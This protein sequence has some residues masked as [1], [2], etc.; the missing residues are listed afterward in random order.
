M[1]FPIKEPV[2]ELRKN[3]TPAEALLWEKLRNRKL[4]GH[5]FVR[6]FPIKYVFEETSRLFIADFYCPQHRLAIELDGSSHTEK[7]EQDQFRDLIMSQQNRRV[8][9]F[10]NNQVID[11]IEALLSTIKKELLF[12]P[13]LEQRGAGGKC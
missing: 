7:K 9:R 4:D 11:H 3:Q 13:S 6:Q 12:S 8:L 5:R 2:R 10:S 1:S